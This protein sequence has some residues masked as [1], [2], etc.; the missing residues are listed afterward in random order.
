MKS[1]SK[2]QFR[3]LVSG[4][5]ENL[6]KMVAESIVSQFLGGVSPEVKQVEAEYSD[7]PILPNSMSGVA[8][9]SFVASPLPKQVVK[10][11]TNRFCP[12]WFQKG[13]RNN[14]LAIHKPTGATFRLVNEEK[15]MG[16]WKFDGWA[17]ESYGGI[18]NTEWRVPGN[19]MSEISKVDSL[20]GY[21][22][23]IDNGMTK[24]GTPRQGQFKGSANPCD[25]YI[26]S[27]NKTLG[28]ICY[29]CK[30]K[31]NQGII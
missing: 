15:N 25:W 7:R 14:N 23:L 18:V 8:E 12:S 19:L 9:K 11:S 22:K 3:E 31:H 20:G 30:R 10:S 1:M 13:L 2:E 6:Q 4:L 5:P 26:P 21:V 17:V 24:K 28:Q 29:S 27:L 16:G